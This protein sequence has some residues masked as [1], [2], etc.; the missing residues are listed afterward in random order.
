MDTQEKCYCVYMH[1]NKLNKK[2]YIGQ[3]CQKPEQRWNKGKGY[4]NNKYFTRA[5]KKYGWD[6]FEHIIL[7]DN[8]TKEEADILEN[9]F[10]LKY[11]SMNPTG[12]NA[13]SGG[14]YGRPS[15]ETRQKMSKAHKGQNLT[16]KTK[17]KISKANKGR[18]VSLET[19]QKISTANKGKIITE[20]TKI[21]MSKAAKGNKAHKGFHHSKESID[22]LCIKVAQYTT[23]KHKLIR[24][25]DSMS[26]AAKTLNI[27]VSNISSCCR[28][29]KYSAGG[30]NWEYYEE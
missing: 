24:I 28:G 7:K 29:N 20:E 11:N 6:N 19:R 16:E 15:Y 5:I 23:K 12:Y 30:F 21:K 2:K 4:F 9:E 14:S 1:I 22:K 3:T 26:E 25:W 27:N 10:I 17:L 8:L 13:K 18:V